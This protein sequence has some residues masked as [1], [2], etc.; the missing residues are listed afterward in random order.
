MVCLCGAVAACAS[1]DSSRFGLVPEL[2]SPTVP[3][4]YPR[5]RAEIEALPYA[6]LGVVLGSG[7]PGIAVLAQYIDGNHLWV[8]GDAFEVLTSPYGRVLAMTVNQRSI[9]TQVIGRDPLLSPPPAGGST[10]RYTVELL[11]SGPAKAQSTNL[12]GA[13]AQELDCVLSEEGAAA[14][15]VASVT[16]DTRKF[17]ERCEADGVESTVHYW[18]DDQGRVRRVDG[19]LYPGSRHLR[20]DVLKVPK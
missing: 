8:G 19:R 3:E 15:V 17:L 18:L 20:F 9:R 16:T 7:R 10:G 12:S 6:Q 2:L 11:V 5:T 13:E 14:I 1:D 4:G